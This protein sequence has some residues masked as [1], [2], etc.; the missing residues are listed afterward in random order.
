MKASAGKL[1]L[2]FIIAFLAML[3]AAMVWKSDDSYYVDAYRPTI[4]KSNERRA[5]AKANRRQMHPEEESNQPQPV[6]MR[7][8]D[9]EKHEGYRSRSF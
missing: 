6:G 4:E 5:K 3:Y 1:I 9:I 7:E 2:L 8:Q